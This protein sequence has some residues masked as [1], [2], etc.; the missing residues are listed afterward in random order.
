MNDYLSKPIDPRQLAEV[1]LC[2]LPKR[3]GVEQAGV[4]PP[5]P[6]DDT[7]ASAEALEIAGF[8]LAATRQ[9]LGDDPE[10]LVS[11]LR[12]FQQDLADWPAQFDRARVAAEPREAVRL[13]HTLNLKTAVSTPRQL[14]A[15]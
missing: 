7:P 2:W 13:A 4:G 3:V 11:I 8:D 9:R 6:Q 14:L 1:L 12:R 15:S 5:A 10:L